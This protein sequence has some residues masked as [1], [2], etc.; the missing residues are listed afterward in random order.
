M[1]KRDLTCLGGSARHRWVPLRAVAELTHEFYCIDCTRV[2]V[3]S[4]VVN[5]LNDWFDITARKSKPVKR[6]GKRKPSQAAPTG[7]PPTTDDAL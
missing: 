2:G 3:G 4:R 7:T 1:N 6:Q 5:D